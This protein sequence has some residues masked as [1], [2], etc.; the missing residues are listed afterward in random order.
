MKYEAILENSRYFKVS[1][2]CR[3]L[4]VTTPNYYRW[5]RNRE[6]NAEK[7][8]TLLPLVKLI[9]KIFNEIRQTYGYRTVQRELEKENISIS[10]YK[11]RRIMRENGLYPV[12]AVKYKPGKADKT[13]YRYSYN[14]L[15]QNFKVNESGKVLVGDITYIKTTIGWVYLVVLVDL[16]NRE[17]VGYK[18]SKQMDSELVKRALSKALDKG[19]KPELFHSNRGCQYSSDSFRRMLKENGIRSSQSKP[20]YPYDN[21]YVESFFATAK[22]ELIYRKRYV[23]KDDVRRDVADYIENFYNRKRLHSY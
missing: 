5:K 8:K 16:Y 20:G 6:K 1:N 10:I 14:E 19:I 4:G 23:I 12:T 7:R 11:I 22:K 3:Y 21:A 17:I 15:K 2:M 9:E 13:K 18:I